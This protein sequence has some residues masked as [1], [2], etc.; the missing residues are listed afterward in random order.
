MRIWL[1]LGPGPLFNA[2][3]EAKIGDALGVRRVVTIGGQSHPPGLHRCGRD[4][5][6]TL[7]FFAALHA[8]VRGTALRLPAVGRLPRRPLGAPGPGAR[9]IHTAYEKTMRLGYIVGT[10]LRGRARRRRHRR[11]AMRCFPISQGDVSARDGAE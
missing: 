5:P 7:G 8:P 10:T 11:F 6:S 2:K 9:G 1:G 4:T 3:T